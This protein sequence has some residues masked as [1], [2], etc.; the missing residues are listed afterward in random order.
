LITLTN[1]MANTPDKEEALMNTVD[2][3]S[4]QATMTWRVGQETAV[5]IDE[6]LVRGTVRKVNLTNDSYLVD[7][8]WP[9]TLGKWK[10]WVHV[11]DIQCAS[12]APP[13]AIS[14][15][16]LKAQKREQQKQLTAPSNPKKRIADASEHVR[17]RSDNGNRK[18][19]TQKKGR[20]S[21]KA[22]KPN[23]ASEQKTSI[24]AQPNS[25]KQTTDQEAMNHIA[26]GELIYYIVGQ[27]LTTGTVL[28]YAPL[29]DQY[30]VRFQVGE[31]EYFSFLP[32]SSI[33]RIPSSHDSLGSAP[34]EPVLLMQTSEPSLVNL[35]MNPGKTAASPPV[36]ED[37]DDSKQM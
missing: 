5:N 27:Q 15:A 34:Q 2:P 26:N 14:G 3:S 7:F 36:V 37:S 18:V 30:A 25:E 22:R 32:A 29:A 8:V 10:Q 17:R 16:E 19:H 28:R 12:K 6:I 23:K 31:E 21:D 9:P 4:T 24:P 11:S 1:R 33:C 20:P 35:T 13:S